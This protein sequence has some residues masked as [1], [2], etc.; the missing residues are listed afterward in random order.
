MEAI[1]Y[2]NNFSLRC[3]FANNSVATGCLVKLLLRNN[4]ETEDFKINHEKKFSCNITNNHLEAYSG[5]VVLDVEADGSEGNISLPVFP[6]EVSTLNEYMLETGCEGGVDI[7]SPSDA[8]RVDARVITG[9]T[10]GSFAAISITIALIT[11]A[12]VIFVFRRHRLPATVSNK[13]C[14]GSYLI[15]ASL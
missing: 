1:F 15:I 6:R 9:A 13:S 2:K 7:E 4:N 5:L 10:V 12:I 11:I 14:G 3:S 8:P